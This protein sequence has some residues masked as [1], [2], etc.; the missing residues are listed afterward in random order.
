MSN[1]RKLY[2]DFIGKRLA[3]MTVRREAEEKLLSA[4]VDEL[5]VLK[6]PAA[7]EFTGDEVKPKRG[8]GRPP[9]TEAA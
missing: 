8:P 5:E 3:W 7:V 6:A 1:L 9:K 2:D 4:I